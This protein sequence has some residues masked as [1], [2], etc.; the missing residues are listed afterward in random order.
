[1]RKLISC[2]LSIAMLISLCIIVKAENNIIKYYSSYQIIKIKG[3]T[4]LNHMN[5]YV[6]VLLMQGE[7]ILNIEQSKI[8]K[9]GRYE[10]SLGVKE[11]PEDVELLVKCGDENITNTVSNAIFKANCWVELPYTVVE[12]NLKY[13]IYA[14][15]S[16]LAE[17]SDDFVV[18][19][20][21]Y[22]ENG[23]LE[24]CK[25]FKSVD[26]ED[27]ATLEISIDK[28]GK[29]KLFAWR[30]TEKM[31]PVGEF[32]DSNSDTLKLSFGENAEMQE[33]GYIAL[34]GTTN[35][36][37]YIQAKEEL[38]EELL[39][40]EPVDIMPAREF[41]V[42]AGQ[43]NGNGSKE[44]PFGTIEQ[45]L[46]EYAALT[47]EAKKYWTAIYV[48]DGTYNITEPIVI[49]SDITGDDGVAKLV[50]SAYEDSEV[51]I[52][53]TANI[54]GNKLKEVT[55][56]DEYYDYIN[57]RA[58][59]KLYY[60]D[61][62]DFKIEKMQGVTYGNNGTIPKIWYDG[63]SQ[64]LA[65]Y[66]NGGNTGIPANDDILD[67][68]Y[69]KQDGE[70]TDYV[71]FYPEDAH[72]LSWNIT[73]G[74][75]VLGQFSTTWHYSNSQVFFDNNAKTVK[76][77]S[78]QAVFQ[79]NQ[80]R[81][82]LV[83]TSTADPAFYYYNVFEELDMS[84]E[85]YYNDSKQKIYIY[86]DT[87]PSVENIL[88]FP[89][90]S[91]DYAIRARN[92]TDLIIRGINFEALPK[93]VSFVGCE[94]TLLQECR[95][96][97]VIS[98]SVYLL[99]CK[100]SGA[101]NCDF[102]DVE[103]GVEIITSWDL[104]EEDG[105][106][107]KIADK[108]MQ[109]LVPQRNFVQNCHFNEVATYCVTTSYAC[110]DVISHNRAENLRNGFAYIRSGTENVVEYNDIFAAG[111]MGNEAYLIYVNGH[112]T[113][114][115]NHI[116]YNYIHNTTPEWSNNNLVVGIPIMFD[117]LNEN[118]FCYG[119]VINKT[120]GGVMLNGGDNHIIE[121]NTLYDVN[122]YDIYANDRM[123][124]ISVENYGKKALSIDRN[125]FGYGFFNYYTKW[126]IGDSDN[127][128]MRRNPSALQR[129]DYY[130]GI[131]DIWTT[132]VTENNANNDLV[133][134]R[135]TT[136]VYVINN[137]VQADDKYTEGIKLNRSWSEYGTDITPE[138]LIYNISPDDV[139]TEYQKDGNDY[140]IVYNNEDPTENDLIEARNALNNKS[141]GLTRAPIYEDGVA[142]D[143]IAESVTNNYID[144]CWRDID[145]ANFYK[146]ILSKDS[147]FNETL[148]ASELGIKSTWLLDNRAR[149]EL[150]EAGTYYYKIEAYS[151]AD[152]DL[153]IPIA[154]SDVCCI[155]VN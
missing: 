153:N 97:N 113:T 39:I 141:V 45:A 40:V 85:W 26:L 7:N 94:R 70:L 104:G 68:G 4:S 17:I 75:G 64:V 101:V 50:I 25:T 57:E 125:E 51:T 112:F 130:K 99:D 61:Y 28:K 78:K 81:K 52:T 103:T 114:R 121:G 143:K 123:Y 74:I 86:L 27:I 46:A 20:A 76:I 118:N 137:K 140:N 88:S 152:D 38:G 19:A 67:R 42:K 6:T 5:E 22:N 100:K 84:G 109:D 72:P 82:P 23:K 10:C 18:I 53:S 132:D 139:T 36:E 49:D 14:D 41:Y 134:A 102:R 127:S 142:V 43:T 11:L 96:D 124:G 138:K 117:D 106:E 3:G 47:D 55:H 13:N 92:V 145:S 91:Q 95:F 150:S 80:C 71:E 32:V 56:E 107:L 98:K 15:M 77:P 151:G 129:V 108:I 146:I 33:R 69:D 119:N 30:S 21:Q 83:N 1:M 54:T 48:L 147:Q 155:Y 148:E 2:V 120:W 90:E 12:D 60:I 35:Y 128:W 79:G 115:N 144:L 116:R 73:E 122:V 93:G 110:G 133:F 9:D 44:S 63:E 16:Q 31:I 66:P 8:G 126:G 62:T 37:R 154:S 135:A 65:R 58:L 149:V 59:G 105:Y 29:L 131:Y 89:T 34:D 111:Y 136:G 24:D 87:P